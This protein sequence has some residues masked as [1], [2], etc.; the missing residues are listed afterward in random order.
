[1]RFKASILVTVEEGTLN[2]IR[3]RLMRVIVIGAV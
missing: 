3:A 2:A 1:M